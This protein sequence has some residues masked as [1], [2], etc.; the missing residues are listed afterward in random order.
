MNMGSWVLETTAPLAAGSALLG[1]V[2]GFLGAVGGAAGYGAGLLG[3]PLAGYTAVLISSTAVPVWQDTRRVSPPLFVASAV[4]AAASLLQLLGKTRREARIVRTFAVAGS[5]AE[6]ASSYALDRA[7]GRV[8][9]VGKP[10]HE[11]RSGAL[12][13]AAKA[14]T[15]A[16]L[17]FSLV[18]GKRR[19]A[20]VA[21]RVLGTAGALAVKFGL[22]EAGKAPAADPRA[23]FQQQRE[24]RGGREVTGKTAVTAPGQAVVS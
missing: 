13:K 15:A 12:L 9:Q 7:G 4:T 3:L 1:G 21:A 2:D 24:G 11:G 6:L 8:E 17:A 22:F 23:T 19:W 20:S 14:C 16:S 10:L 18:S 5:V